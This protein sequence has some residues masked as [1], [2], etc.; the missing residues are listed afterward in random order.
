MVDAGSI[1]ASGQTTA[2]ELAAEVPKDIDIPVE[3]KE[4]KPMTLARSFRRMKID[5]NSEDREIIHRVKETVDQQLTRDFGSAYAIMYDIANT[6]REPETVNGEVQT[7]D[8]GLTVWKQKPDGSYYEDWD[9]I[10]YKERERFIYR[11]LANAFEWEQ[12][13]ADIWGEAIFAK[14]R[15]EEAFATSFD[16]N[17]DSKATVD[18]RTARANKLAAD[19]KYLAVYKSYYSRKAEALVRIMMLILQRMK[20]LHVN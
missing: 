13:A 12:T 6:V 3:P 15:L 19:E 18:A 16:E 17:G 2:D 5:W 10:G 7:D 20:D 8:Y 14:A 9:Q 11:I 4:D 1:R